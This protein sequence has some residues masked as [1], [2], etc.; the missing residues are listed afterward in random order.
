MIVFLFGMYV[1][2]YEYVHVSEVLIVASK[3]QQI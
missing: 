2:V 1:C 3:G